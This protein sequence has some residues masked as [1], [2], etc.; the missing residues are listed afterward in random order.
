MRYPL[1]DGVAGP[2]RA[3]DGAAGVT[4]IYDARCSVNLRPSSPGFPGLP[5]PPPNDK[6][7]AD[8]V[9]GRSIIGRA[10]SDYSGSAWFLCAV[11]LDALDSPSSS[12][13]L[14]GSH[15]HVIS[16]RR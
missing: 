1:A 13:K 9:L 11:A 3:G 4:T 5:A 12:L 15:D 14:S 7:S 2:R 6:S 10:T 16:Q 8:A